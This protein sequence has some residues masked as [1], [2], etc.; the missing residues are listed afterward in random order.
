MRR[1]NDFKLLATAYLAGFVLL[2]FEGLLITLAHPGAAAMEEPAPAVEI[3]KIDPLPGAQ[4]PGIQC[5]T[6]SLDRPVD[7]L[8]RITSFDSDCRLETSF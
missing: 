6:F 4:R 2:G 3:G 1:R 5:V 8:G 7:R